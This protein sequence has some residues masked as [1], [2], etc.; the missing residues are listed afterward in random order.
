MHINEAI[1][2][3]NLNMEGISRA[4]YLIGLLSAFENRFQ[5]MADKQMGEISWKQFFLI[6]CVN[7]CKEDPTIKELAEIVGSSHQNIK[8]LLLKLEHKGFV[9]VYSDE[10]DKRKQRIRLTDYCS[11]FCSRND[12]MSGIVMSQMFEGISEEHLKIT[13]NTI[14]EIE[15]NMKGIE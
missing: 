4:Y 5:A 8:Q 11:E 12:E 6:I 1:T 7:M 10:K 3:E 15:K 13:I 14:I 2:D 9:N